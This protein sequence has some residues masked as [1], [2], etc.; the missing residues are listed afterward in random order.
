MCKIADVDIYN[1]VNVDD[2]TNNGAG[3]AGDR[4]ANINGTDI[5]NGIVITDNEALH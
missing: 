4:I 1:N 3:K 5:Y 2:W